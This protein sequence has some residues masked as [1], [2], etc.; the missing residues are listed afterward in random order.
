MRKQ[1]EAL[2]NNTMPLGNGT[3]T[4][5]AEERAELYKQATE[6]HPFVHQAHY[7]TTLSSN[8]HIVDAHGNTVCILMKAALPKKAAKLAADVLRPAATRTSLRANIFGGESPLSGIAG[9]FDYAGS[10]IEFKCRKTSFTCEA[11]ESWPDVFPMVECVNELY[12]AHLPA[13]WTKQ[14]AA[15]PDPVRVRGTVFSTLTINQRFR[16]AQHTDAGDFDEGFGVLTVLEGDYNGLNLGFPRHGVCVKMNVGDVILFNTHQFHA[17]TELERLPDASSGCTD[18]SR[19]T[20]VLYYRA[21]LGASACMREYARRY[22]EAQEAASKEPAARSE[23]EAIAAEALRKFP[24]G[25]QPT[26]NGVNLNRPAAVHA[27]R[28]SPFAMLLASTDTTQRLGASAATLSGLVLLHLLLAKETHGAPEWVTFRR[29]VYAVGG[30]ATTSGAE[31]ESCDIGDFV[32]EAIFAE[33]RVDVVATEA[34]AKRRGRAEPAA[35]PAASCFFPPPAVPAASGAGSKAKTPAAACCGLTPRDED[36]LCPV[37]LNVNGY[38]DRMASK[39]GGFSEAGGVAE[40]GSNHHT[41]LAHDALATVV[42]AA[43]LDMWVEARR[44]WLAFVKRDWLK[45]VARNPA[46]TDFSWANKSDMNTAFFDLCDVGSGVMLALLGKEEA[47]DREEARFWLAFAV[48]LH[49]ACKTEN[50]MHPDAMSMKKLNVKLKDHRFG[51]TRYFKDQTPE[52]QARRL[53]RKENIMKARQNR[54]EAEKRRRQR[55]REL[56]LDSSDD[57][58]DGEHDTDKNQSWLDSD[59]FDY[60]TEDVPPNYAALGLHPPATHAKAVHGAFA[61]HTAQLTAAMAGAVTCTS[62]RGAVPTVFD[63]LSILVLCGAR[64]SDV[65]ARD[66]LAAA[67]RAA[68]SAGETAAAE[69]ARRLNCD[70]AVEAIWSAALGSVGQQAGPSNAALLKA[71]AD[72]V[73]A[74]A[75]AAHKADAWAVSWD[76]DVVVH[77]LPAAARGVD[78]DAAAD[79]AAAGYGTGKRQRSGAAA[80][81]SDDDG[82]APAG[83]TALP[84]APPLPV[85]RRLKLRLTVVSDAVDVLLGTPR[86][87]HDAVA[88]VAP[89]GSFDLV[90][91][92][93]VF[94]QEPDAG[95]I[96]LRDGDVPAEGGTRVQRMLRAARGFA[97]SPANGGPSSGG[98][99]IVLVVEP[100]AADQHHYMLPQ[101]TRTATEAATPAAVAL[102]AAAHTATWWNAATAAA[103][104]SAA[105]ALAAFSA[106]PALRSYAALERLLLLPPTVKPTARLPSAPPDD[107]ERVVEF[108]GTYRLP[109]SPLGTVV[110]LLPP[111]V[112]TA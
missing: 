56:G 107:A 70:P 81:D 11:I 21:N 48:H 80:D 79:A 61:P 38:K 14:N 77:V 96:G 41:F 1:A 90:L 62:P 35:A 37:D 59:V 60:Q 16:T 65:G 97:K 57:D 55:R 3:R 69:F 9:Y 108:Y 4:L 27:A 72:A 43:L 101:A 36:E 24:D 31:P 89:T 93:G 87:G 104:P 66:G 25:V 42:P 84:G 112:L 91:L 102:L 47:T 49:E 28:P 45:M 98:G 20:C 15:I 22:R 7:H 94:A 110:A 5:T 86:A 78:G 92:R 85:A 75:P 68:A 33:R 58:G 13:R 6:S 34:R 23:E 105:A 40:F 12:K 30:K 10:P 63:Q 53:L 95:N 88:S 32:H 103:P 111:D 8:A 44:K 64:Q 51:G 74:A 99:G 46:R 18:W 73:E 39:L 71:V 17:N 2:F 29:T 54:S 76:I 106:P 26:Q 83:R 50:A 100:D 52:E 19:V 82:A 67:L 109:R